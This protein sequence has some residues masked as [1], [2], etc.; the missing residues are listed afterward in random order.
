MTSDSSIEQI[1]PR[2]FNRR[3]ISGRWGLRHLLYF[4]FWMPIG[5]IL[6]PIR[7][8]IFWI[9]GLPTYIIFSF[10]G[11][12]EWFFRFWFPFVG[13]IIK[14]K[15]RKAFFDTPR[16]PPIIVS[17][18]ITDYDGL[19]FYSLRGPSRLSFITTRY[20]EPIARYAKKLGLQ[21][22]VVYRATNAA[23]KPKVK[24]DIQ[25][26]LRTERR[27]LFV[28]AEG[29]TTSGKHGLLRYNKFVFSLDMDVLP[30]ALRVRP[31]AP[32]NID[33][34]SRHFLPNMLWT[35]SCPFVVYEYEFLEPQRRKDEETPEQFAMRVQEY[36]A[37]H[38]G[39]ACTQ[40]TYKDKNKIKGVT[41]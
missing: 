28:L 23:D 20:L 12:P 24:R 5:A 8:L 6:V 41:R 32:I 18:H 21:V 37:Q 3:R 27:S 38:L 33:I 2:L 9:I 26:V 34:P 30:V 10:C 1:P 4:I 7:L 39:I 17:N 31:Y 14:S 22:S 15:N 29:A 16:C 19:V 36:T 40:F 11:H 35:F 25:S 13:I